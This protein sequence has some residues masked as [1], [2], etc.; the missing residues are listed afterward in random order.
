MHPFRG[1]SL[2]V[3]PHTGDELLQYKL[4]PIEGCNLIHIL[5]I[6]KDG[7]DVVVVLRLAEKAIHQVYVEVLLEALVAVFFWLE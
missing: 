6:F 3:L 5:D 1:L 2:L 4:A 7:L